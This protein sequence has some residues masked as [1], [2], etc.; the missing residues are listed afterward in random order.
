MILHDAMILWR[1]ESLGDSERYVVY[2]SSSQYQ[3]FSRLCFD[4]VMNMRWIR[5]DQKPQNDT[6]PDDRSSAGN[7]L[8]RINTVSS[9]IG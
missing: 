7:I 1:T 6:T 8:M 5:D 4:T 3:R 2:D 9:Q